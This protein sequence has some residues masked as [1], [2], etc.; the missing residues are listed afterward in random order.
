MILSQSA[1]VPELL[2]TG[3]TLVAAGGIVAVLGRLAV[4]SQWQL[5]KHESGE[6]RRLE[7]RLDEQE[8]ISDQREQ[9]LR[10]LY[11]RAMAAHRHCEQELIQHKVQAAAQMAT[12]QARINE[13]DLRL[14][15]PRRSTDP[16]Q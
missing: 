7:D 3:I 16:D 6:R 4:W 12:L 11:D 2:Q 10:D 9:T 8:L 13:L 5:V 14:N 1:E 15:R